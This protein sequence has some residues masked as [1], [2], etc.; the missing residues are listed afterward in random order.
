MQVGEEIMVTAMNINGT[1]EGR[2]QNKE[3]TFPFNYVEFVD[4]DPSDDG[5]R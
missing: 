1:W 5:N 4:T 3:G 2:G